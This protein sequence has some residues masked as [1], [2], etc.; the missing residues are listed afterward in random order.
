VPVGGGSPVT[1]SAVGEMPTWSSDGRWVYFRRNDGGEAHVWKIPAEGGQ[2]VHAVTRTGLVAREAPGGGD[3][4]FVGLEGG[5][6]HRSAAGDETLVIPEF[7]NSMLG[8][9]TVVSDGVYYVA[10]ERHPDGTVSYQLKFF[11][12]ARRRT[13][14][15]GILAGMLDDWVGGLT[16]SPDRRV[17]LYS[18]RA[19]ETREVMLVDRF[20]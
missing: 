8:Y 10:E 13:S 12:F 7:K 20:R 5:I 17:L 19:Y 14:H 3:L 15:V 11:E 16:L 18:Q 2:A 6:W 9:W 4:Y 1:L